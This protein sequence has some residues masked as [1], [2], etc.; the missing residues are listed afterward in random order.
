MEEISYGLLIILNKKKNIIFNEK[1][2]NI[3]RVKKNINHYGIVNDF[4][5]KKRSNEDIKNIKKYKLKIGYKNKID[6]RKILILIINKFNINI[7]YIGQI[8][9][10]NK[11][12]TIKLPK[13]M[14]NNKKKIKF[15]ILKN[16]KNIIKI[17]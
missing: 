2:N 8:K 15:L 14:M 3:F 9:I 1:K 17:I 4:Y 13:Y 5:N 16:K 10:F 12:S 7:K 6:P 11:F